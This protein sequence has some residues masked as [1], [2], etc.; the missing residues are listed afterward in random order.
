MSKLM[1]GISEQI[2]CPHSFRAGGIAG[3]TVGMS[4]PCNE[5]NHPDKKIVEVKWSSISTED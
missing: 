3:C 1:E 4:I 2:T 5:C